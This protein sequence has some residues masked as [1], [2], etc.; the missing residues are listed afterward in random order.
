VLIVLALLVL[1]VF[2]WCCL[3]RLFVKPV[4][5]KRIKL[6]QL[7]LP[8]APRNLIVWIASIVYVAECM[9]HQP[10]GTK[11]GEILSYYG[12]GVGCLLR[13]WLE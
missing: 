4:S 3:I 7:W 12:L 10:V 6:W 13:Y 5:S 11:Y 9:R 8:P 1:Q 2:S